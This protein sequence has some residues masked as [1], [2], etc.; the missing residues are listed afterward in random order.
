MGGFFGITSNKDCLLDVFF[1]TDYHSHLGTQRGG[2]AAYDP[3]I[4]LQR[5]IHSITSA[6]FR[7]KFENIFAE[8]SGIS[9]IGCISDTDPQPMLIRSHHGTYAICTI[10]LINNAEQ[11][12]DLYFGGSRGHFDAMTGGR[13]NTVELVAALIDQKENFADGIKY[14]QSLIDGTCSILIL[15]QNGHLIAARDKVG[16]IPVIVCKG[17]DGY[18]VTFESFAAQKLGYTPVRELGPAEIVEL[19]PNDGIV[20]LSKPGKEMKMCAFLWSYYGYPTSSYEGVNVEAMRYRNGELMAELDMASGNAQE[21]DYVAGVPDSGVPHAIG[22]ANISH[23]AYARPYIKYTPTWSRS[24]TPQKQADRAKV[25]RMKQIPVHELIENKKLL[26]VD[27][28]IVRG[29]QLKETVD[30]LYANGAKEVHM[31]SA[32][33]PIM[34]GCKYLNFSRSTGDMELITRRTILELEGTE[35][36]EHL[37]EYSD[38]STERGRALR[39]SISDKFGFASLEFQTLEGVVKAIGLPPEQL[40]TYC[41]NGKE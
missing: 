19:S 10:G 18:A 39:K 12:I 11:L 33:P 16:R 8:M 40:C 30:F 24:F 1:G 9:A 14:A 37:E 31:R 28:S 34:Y 25:A 6:P 29:T 20:Q 22:Y 21:L 4:G 35:G 41:W 17:E 26:F 7:T 36:F 38:G 27:D 3:E 23:T 5:K 15:K 2:L 32:C 13:V